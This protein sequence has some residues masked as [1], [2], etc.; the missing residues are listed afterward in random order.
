MSTPGPTPDSS[1]DVDDCQVAVVGAGAAGLCAA[2][3][4]A[5]GGARVIALDGAE[6]L[7]RKILISGG[8]RCNVLPS[9]SSPDDFQTAGSRNVLKRLLRTWRLED[10]RSWFEDELGL[11]LKREDE[12][13]KLFPV[14]DKAREVRDR[15]IE[16]CRAQGVELRHPWK[17]AA[18]AHAEAAADDGSTPTGFLLT[19]DDGRTLRAARVVL[20]TGGQSV[21]QTGSDGFGYR[22]AKALGHSILPTYPALVPLTSNESRLTELSGLSLK[23]LWRARKDGRTLEEREREL[24]FTHK[25]FSGPAVLDASHWAVHHGAEIVVAWEGW[26]EEQWIAYLNGRAR[27]ALEKTLAD[28]LPNRLAAAL[29]ALAGLRGEMRCGNLDRGTRARLL[30]VLCDF[31]LPVSGNRGFQFAEVTGGGIPLGEVDPSTLHSRATP[32]LYLCGEMLDVIGRIGGY[33]FLWAWL[34]GRLAGE[35]AAR[36]DA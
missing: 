3:W 13:G 17:V 9:E 14:S 1:G 24:L 11:A 8:G 22:L 28:V 33:N 35:A 36:A 15:L 25:G 2:W 30:Q 26:D 20:A 4:A 16:G 6:E 27:R 32:G 12:T 18:I 7:G 19:A 34:T 29:V 21:P 23:V 10:Q 5:R 31:P